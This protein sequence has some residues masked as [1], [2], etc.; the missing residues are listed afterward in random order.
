MVRIEHFQFADEGIDRECDMRY[1]LATQESRRKLLKGGFMFKYFTA[2]ASAAAILIVLIAAGSGFGAAPENDYIKSAFTSAQ[3]AFKETGICI[4]ESKGSCPNAI[5]AAANAKRYAESAYSEDISTGAKNRV[6][7]AIE[8]LEKAIEE[9][10]GNWLNEAE[11]RC[12]YA[13]GALD[14]ALKLL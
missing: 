13:M 12:G 5:E 8:I 6:K 14:D 9:L 1:C 2:R 7:A 10:R 11:V 3:T 4:K